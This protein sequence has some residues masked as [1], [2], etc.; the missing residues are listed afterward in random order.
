MWCRKLVSTVRLHH[1]GAVVNYCS[2]Y[3]VNENLFDAAGPSS[4]GLSQS[5]PG[6]SSP[7]RSTPG[8]S[9][10][11]WSPAH[12]VIPCYGGGRGLGDSSYPVNNRIHI[13]GV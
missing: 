11:G 6:R 7:G 3:L 4:S 1:N 12:N 9:S 13:T 5:S 8:G 10:H 2:Q